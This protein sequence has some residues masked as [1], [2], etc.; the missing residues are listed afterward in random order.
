MPIAVSYLPESRI[1]LQTGS[2]DI[3]VAEI[4][5]AIDDTRAAVRANN[6]RG[7]VIDTR[8][9]LVDIPMA[10]WIDLTITNDAT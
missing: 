9:D 2:G 5:G 8:A 6:P 10:A 4:D 3:A 1:V 7:V